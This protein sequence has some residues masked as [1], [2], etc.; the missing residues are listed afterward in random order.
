[1]GKKAVLGNFGRDIA[2][3]E[4]FNTFKLNVKDV[5]YRIFTRLLEGFDKGQLL[6]IGCADGSFLRFLK[7]K[8]WEVEGIEI[9][10]ELVEK[11]RKVGLSVQSIDAQEKLPFSPE[12]FDVVLAGEVIEHMVNVDEFLKNCRNVLKPG[13]RIII[14]TPNLVSLKNRILMFF[15]GKPRFAYLDC[16]YSMFVLSDLKDIVARH[17]T[18]EDVL[19]N[20]VIV[21]TTR[22]RFFW[23]FEKIANV[24]P[25]LAEHIIVVA[26]K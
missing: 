5:R 21:S 24:L 23:P 22:S 8:G 3:I 17:F 2:Q 4:R 11:A 9:A 20:Y 15:G 10:P 13:G 26:R 18:I 12:S 6:E 25:T 16:H 19:G 1:M 7:T 14:S